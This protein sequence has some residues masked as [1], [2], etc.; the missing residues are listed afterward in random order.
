MEIVQFFKKFIHDT[1]FSGYLT[2][3]NGLFFLILALDRIAYLFFQTKPLTESVINDIQKKVLNGEYNTVLQICNM[4]KNNP[5]L[6]MIKS[7]V[8]S[9]DGGREAVKSALGASLVKITKECERRVNLIGLTASVATLLGLLGTITGLITT[10]KAIEIADAASKSAKL[11]SGIS[12]AMYSTAAGILIGV[13]AMVVHAI[14]NTKID[15][16]TSEAQHT[17]YLLV[18]NIEKSEKQDKK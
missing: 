14:V 6:K 3:A 1:G 2:I 18:S 4:S 7:G 10:F 9:I 11:S 16:I 13:S 12:E 15:E 5:Q 8:L 17:G